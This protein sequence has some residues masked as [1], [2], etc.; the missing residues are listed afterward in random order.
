MRGQTL[1]LVGLGNIARALVPKALGF[2]LDTVAYTPRL[3]PD[4][5]PPGVRT[6]RSLDELLK[7]ADYVSLHV[8]SKPETKGLIGEAE[9]RAMKP[10]AYLI[11]TSR[12][13]LVD[14]DALARAIENGWIA[15]A[16]L[17]VLCDEPPASDHPLVR[18]DRVLL[19]PH[20]AFYSEVAI[21]ELENKGSPK[22][23]GGS[24]GTGATD[25]YQPRGAR[26]SLFAT[27]T[28]RL[29]S[30]LPTASS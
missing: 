1:G 28:H 16:A 10:T 29:T 6:V 3:Q 24:V 9:L 8:P 5:A 27:P 19:T 17:D 11:N 13:A 20:A 7:A 4:A 15:G 22:R 12:G 30:T 26:P 2:G 14:E 18:L 21:A 23:G 25:R